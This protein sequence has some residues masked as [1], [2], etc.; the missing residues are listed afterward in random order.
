MSEL[1]VSKTGIVRKID[2]LGRIMI[3]HELRKTFHIKEG[4]SFEIGLA[5]AKKGLTSFLFTPYNAYMHCYKTQ[6]MNMA[7]EIRN[8]IPEEAT[9]LVTSK[10]SKPKFFK[11]EA[12]KLDIDSI[13]QEAADIFRYTPP[14]ENNCI[15]QNHYTTLDDGKNVWLMV[16]IYSF[17]E[18]N[19]LMF[20]IAAEEE[21]STEKKDAISAIFKIFG[22]FFNN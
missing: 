22:S 4:D 16:A 6:V 9:L 12:N 2:D 3:P 1:K 8:L 10:W 11:T 19:Q 5:Q 7:N 17:D 20:T 21:F 14:N 15:I 18:S 13:E